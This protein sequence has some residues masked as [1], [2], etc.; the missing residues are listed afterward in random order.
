LGNKK[1]TQYQRR[2]EASA[3][4]FMNELE[5]WA[6]FGKIFVFQL[7]ILTTKADIRNE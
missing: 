1:K 4:D 6:E 7:S 5:I 2:D 3:E